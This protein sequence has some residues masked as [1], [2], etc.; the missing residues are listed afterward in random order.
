KLKAFDT[1][2]NVSAASDEVSAVAGRVETHDLAPHAISDI[3]IYRDSGQISTTS[4]SYTTLPGT[5]VSYEANEPSTLLIVAFGPAVGYPASQATGYLYSYPQCRLVVNGVVVD[6]DPQPPQSSGFEEMVR[7]M[8]WA[9]T[10]GTFYHKIEIGEGETFPFT[11]NVRLEW[12]IGRTNANTSSLFRR[13]LNN[14]RGITF[15]SLKR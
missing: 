8:I 6:E 9:S 4:T 13:V 3:K 15:I 1:S 11:V 12:R 5:N 10:P 2:G 14:R 7:D